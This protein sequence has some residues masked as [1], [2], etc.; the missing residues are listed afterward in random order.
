MEEEHKEQSNCLKTYISRDPRRVRLRRERK[1]TTMA[2]GSFI[3]LKN[4]FQTG[5]QFISRQP[6]CSSDMDQTM[7]AEQLCKKFTHTWA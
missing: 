3:H 7:Q 1:W 5:S 6:V 4:A 2:L